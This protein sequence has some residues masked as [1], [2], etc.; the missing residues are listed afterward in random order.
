MTA[1]APVRAITDEEAAFYHENG[2]VKLEQF[3]PA[4]VAAE[5][6]EQVKSHIEQAEVAGRG[7]ADIYDTDAWRDW[8]W[9]ARDEKLEPFVSVS[10][11][12]E[13]GRNVRKLIGR[14]V[15]IRCHGDM[16]AVKMP[17]GHGASKPTAYHQD[18]PNF[19]FDRAGMMSFWI[20]LDD[21]P[22]ERGSMRFVSGSH[23]EG[24]LGRMGFGAED[25]VE[26]YPHLLQRHE[27]SPPI[28]LR[29]GD[30]TAHDGLVVH[31]APENST[32]RPRWAYITSYYPADV[33]Y[34]GADHHI[35]TR[36]MGLEIGQAID[37][38]RFAAVYP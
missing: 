28:H 6:L 21:V 36:D 14:E 11:S 20:A 38:D 26:Y 10:F 13:T 3:V 17:A 8:H 37:H 2:W 31:G 4:G 27:L 9:I 12:A 23:R 34:T 32:D 30:A 29:A 33:R 1:S 22:P 7:T 25:M 5:M 18:F 19:P 35:F 15:G 24:S 16:M